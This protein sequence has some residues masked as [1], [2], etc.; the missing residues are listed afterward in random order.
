LFPAGLPESQR[1]F[2]RSSW[3]RSG[4]IKVAGC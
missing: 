4:M 2:R 1:N 3:H